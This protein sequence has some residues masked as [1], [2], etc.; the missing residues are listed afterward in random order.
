V[1]R[2][3]HNS[4]PAFVEVLISPG[5]QASGYVARV[6]PHSVSFVEVQISSGEHASGYVPRVARNRFSFLC[7]GAD[8]PLVSRH[9]DTWPALPVTVLSYSGEVLVFPW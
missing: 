1:A 3:A 5:G 7:R 8:S 2:V 6:A 9:Q 4:F